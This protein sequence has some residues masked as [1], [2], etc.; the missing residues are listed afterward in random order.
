M[1]KQSTRVGALR[2][3]HLRWLEPG[4]EDKGMR[5]LANLLLL[6]K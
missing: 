2:P 3:L 1:L 4:R 6:V 5:H